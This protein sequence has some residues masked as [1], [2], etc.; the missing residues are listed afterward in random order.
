[1]IKKI[2]NKTFN[3]VISVLALL[4]L[5]PLLISSYFFACVS[6]YAYSG[7]DGMIYSPPMIKYGGPPQPFDINLF[8]LCKIYGTVKSNETKLPVGGVKLKITK[9]EIQTLSDES[10]Y[11]AFELY[12]L[13]S[14]TYEIEIRDG[15]SDIILQTREVVFSK[16][17]YHSKQNELSE[18]DFM[19]SVE[20]L[21]ILI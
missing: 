16:G 7:R 9:P 15:K 21:E 10:G 18:Q 12:N 19:V 4:L 2:K 13:A 5:F 17:K 1:M 6:S 11:F 8:K 14:D 20:T 3:L